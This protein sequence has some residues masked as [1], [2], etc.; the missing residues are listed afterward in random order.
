MLLDTVEELELIGPHVSPTDLLVRLFHE[1]SA[2][3]STPSR[4][5]RLHLLGGQGAPEPVD[6]FGQGHRHMTT[7]QGVVTADCQFCGAHYRLDPATLGFEA[8]ATGA[9]AGGPG[10]GPICARRLRPPVPG[11]G[12]D[13]RI[14]TSIR[15]IRRGP[16]ICDPGRG[17]DRGRPGPGGGRLWL[18]KRPRPCA[19]IPARSPAG[20]ADRP[21]R[22]RP[23][24]RRAARGRGGDRPAARRVEVWGCPTTRR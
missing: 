10:D 11:A 5:L 12:R 17:A 6:L 7:E 23:R 24:G 16:P 14:S 13:R 2:A 1:E 8:R 22:C 9:G 3:C 15:A 20:R 19:T 21:G 4:S 18:T